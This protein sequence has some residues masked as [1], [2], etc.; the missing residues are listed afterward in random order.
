MDNMSYHKTY[1]DTIPKIFQAK[2]VNL[3]KFLWEK[4][5]P[6]C[7]GNTVNILAAHVKE[8]IIN[9]CKYQTVALAEEQGQKVIFTP[10]HYS[11]LQPI[12]LVWALIKGNVG[13]QYSLDSTLALVLQRLVTSSQ[14][15]PIQSHT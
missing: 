7:L 10:P 15:R 2:K 3:Q 13:R 12:E 1:D 4:K 9:H 8:F 5:I 6:F 14:V 11:D